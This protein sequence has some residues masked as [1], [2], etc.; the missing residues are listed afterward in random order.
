[1]SKVVLLMDRISSSDPLVEQ[2]LGIC[3]CRRDRL[4]LELV[5][6]LPL[7]SL[8]PRKRLSMMVLQV[9]WPL[10]DAITLA[11]SIVKSLLSRLWQRSLFLSEFLCFLSI[12]TVATYTS[13]FFQP[14]P[15]LEAVS[16]PPVCSPL[17]LY[18]VMF[19]LH[20]VYLYK[21]T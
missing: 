18:A 9:H 6:N 13:H 3:R 11:L 1:M 4:D 2:T 21:R 7:L 14:W 8:R 19:C 20:A 10:V 15:S 12:L 5:S 17:F 16:R